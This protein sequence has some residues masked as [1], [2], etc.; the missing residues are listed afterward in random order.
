MQNLEVYRAV[1]EAQERGRR[2]ALCTV[3]R[4][5]G[6]VP[7]HEGSKMLVFADGTLV[8]TVGGGEM[9]SQTIARAVQIARG[10][11]QAEVFRYPLADPGRGD[12]GVC[13]GTVEIFI[14]P[15]SA[16]ATVFVIGAGHVGRA[17]VHLAKWLGFR[18]AVTD[19]REELCTLEQC[20]GADLYLPG[21]LAEVLPEAGV[22]DQT[23]VCALTR[24][25]KLDVEAVP[26]LLRTP[27]PYI[28]VIGSR[29]RWAVAAKE[30]QARGVPESEL[31]RV[32]SPLGLE[33]KAET[34]E[35]IALSIMA[36]IIALRS[37]GT[38]EPMKW[39]GEPEEAETTA[40]GQDR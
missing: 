22:N 35:E 11:R 1:L 2:A 10:E 21:P 30:L 20:P 13:G 32:H 8:G 34:P 27:A 3:V 28:G 29:R 24:A 26:L 12:P 18:V 36:E 16:P 5:S 38:G 23:Y 31:K 6:S 4:T 9:E 15:L 40:A 37:G 25:Y 7:R 33:L 19:D 39:W 14:E 17:V